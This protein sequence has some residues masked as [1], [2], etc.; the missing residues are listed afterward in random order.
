L[1]RQAV[2]QRER[3]DPFSSTASCINSNPRRSVAEGRE[4]GSFFMHESTKSQK[5]RE[6]RFER[7]MIGAGASMMRVA[8][9]RSDSIPV[10]G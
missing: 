7:G 4:T 10:V 6:R 1:R 8:R 5:A 3:R 9:S 2:I